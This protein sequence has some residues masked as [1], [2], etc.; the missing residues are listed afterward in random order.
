MHPHRSH[1][2]RFAFVCLATLAAAAAAR[3][4]R[5]ETTADVELA[6]RDPQGKPLA[7]APVEIQPFPR[8]HTLDK[9][10]AV[11]TTTD[12]RGVAR[13]AWPVGVDHVQIVAKG[14]GYGATGTFEVLEGKV[15]LSGDGGPHLYDSIYV[16]AAHGA[17]RNPVEAI[18]YPTAAADDE[19]VARF[20]DLLPGVYTIYASAGDAGAVQGLREDRLWLDRKPP[21][22]VCSGVA[23]RAGETR[24]FQMAVYPQPNLVR[25]QVLQPDGKPITDRNP[26]FDWAEAVNSSGWSS[27]MNLDE[28]GAGVHAFEAPGLWRVAF[29]YRDSPVHWFPVRDAPY[30]E[31][32]AVVAVSP[33]LE[34]GPPVVLTA[35]RHDPGVLVAR[36]QDLDGNPA[37]APS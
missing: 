19:G 28:N 6:V 26:A 16:G 21:H 15:T 37:P 14:V 31:A 33:L 3:E 32:A 35:H 23:V 29:R 12:D 5:P 30:Y 36:L 2:V 25:F 22:G 18:L 10:T 27:G 17:E 11:K 20:Q 9:R 7:G 24:K 13:F 4:E 1:P 34:N 8:D